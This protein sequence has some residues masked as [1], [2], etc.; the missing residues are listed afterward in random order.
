MV[1]LLLALALGPV[2]AMPTS[3]QAPAP[4]PTAPAGRAIRINGVAARP[5]DLAVLERL[6][7]AWGQKVPDGDYWYD[8]RSGVSG[9]W[10]GPATAFLGAGL[11]LGGVPVPANASGGGTGTLSGVFVNGREL[12]PVDVMGL[13][14]ILGQAPW[15]GQWWVDA[16]GNYGPL[17][18]PAVGNLVWIANQRKAAGGGSY[19]R[20]DLSSGSSVYVGS[21]CAA[22]SGR[23]SPSDSS[24]SY[25]YY[26]GCD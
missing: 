14:Q 17:G 18:M 25:S 12:H 13:A 6:E 7:A 1:P 11:G 15:P 4:P 19:Y 8:D 26:V 5:Q 23:L 3:P 20:S 22:V 9:P 24:S 16:Q 10:G 2:F 21:G